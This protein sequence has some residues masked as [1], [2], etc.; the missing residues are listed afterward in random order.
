MFAISY[1]EFSAEFHKALWH[2][3]FAQMNEASEAF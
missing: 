2:W 1:P 3:N